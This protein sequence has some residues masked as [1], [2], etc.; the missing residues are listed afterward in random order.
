MAIQLVEGD[1]KKRAQKCLQ[2]IMQIAESYD[3]DIVPDITIFGSQLM[4]K[5]MVVPKVRHKKTSEG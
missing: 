2:A 5:I 4:P 1:D 3:C